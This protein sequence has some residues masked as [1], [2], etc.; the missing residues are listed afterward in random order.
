MVQHLKGTTAEDPV[1]R[2]AV[3]VPGAATA[4][5][6]TRGIRGLNRSSPDQ[7]TTRS[8]SLV[9]SPGSAQGRLKDNFQPSRV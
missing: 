8:S 1:G 3:C 4:M 5:T 9:A 2:V 6:L 7:R